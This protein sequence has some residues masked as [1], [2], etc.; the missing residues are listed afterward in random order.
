[1]KIVELKG[2]KNNLIRFI[3]ADNLEFMAEV[4]W[5]YY[6]LAVVDPPYGINITNRML[7]KSMKDYKAKKAKRK[8]QDWDN[9][10]PDDKYWD[11]LF[12]TTRQ[13]II[14]GGNYFLEYLCACKKYYLWDKEQPE[15]LSFSDCEFA[16]TSFE[17]APRMIKRSRQKDVKHDKIHDTQ[18][19]VY[20]YDAIFNDC[21]KWE[22]IKIGDRILDTHGG[23]H[24]IAIAAWRHNLSI[25]IVEREEHFHLEG[26][27]N[28]HKHCTQMRAD[29]L[30]EV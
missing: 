28:F 21:F 13:Q 1:M 10:T 15:D 11:L 7:G 2:Q 17:G 18:K 30:F 24:N 5:H 19:P 6:H 4:D 22:H 27:K 12:Y 8:Q 25:D 20:L 3:H 16:W 26:I 14:W 23:S 9:Q 29:L